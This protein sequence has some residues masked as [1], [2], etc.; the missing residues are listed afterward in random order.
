ME[1]GFAWAAASLREKL[2]SG[3]RAEVEPSERAEDWLERPLSFAPF[4]CVSLLPRP[5]GELK[6]SLCPCEPDALWA[7]LGS[8]PLP[9]HRLSELLAR[10]D[11]RLLLGRAVPTYTSRCEVEVTHQ[12]VELAHGFKP[13]LHHVDGTLSA[14]Q[15]LHHL[16]KA[17]APD[18]LVDAVRAAFEQLMAKGM[19]RTAG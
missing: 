4:L 14:E 5:Y 1:R 16:R 12:I 15:L 3:E 18:R 6:R 7:R 19:L 8:A 17:A 9:A 11:P 13:I 2:L 10:E